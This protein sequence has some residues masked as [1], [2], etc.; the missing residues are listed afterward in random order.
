MC[1]GGAFCKRAYSATHDDK[2]K[3]TTH[4]SDNEGSCMGV[5]C[6]AA[7]SFELLCAVAA[8]AH[9]SLCQPTRERHGPLRRR[10]YAAF[11][12]AIVTHRRQ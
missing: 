7:V 2:H 11:D 6:A 3:H 4:R 12:M 1:G 8:F 9:T 10:S 5:R